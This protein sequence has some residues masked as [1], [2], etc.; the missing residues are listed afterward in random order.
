MLKIF[1]QKNLRL[2]ISKKIN[3]CV[4]TVLEK[5]KNVEDLII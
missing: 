1:T 5:P 3:I 4:F 2:L